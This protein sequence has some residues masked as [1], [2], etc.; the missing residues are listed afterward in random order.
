[1][2]FVRVAMLTKLW[3]KLARF[4]SDLELGLAVHGERIAQK[5]SLPGTCHRTLVLIDH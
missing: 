2:A 4:R 5:L 3:N 1:M